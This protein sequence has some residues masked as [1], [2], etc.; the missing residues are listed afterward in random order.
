MES[1]WPPHR[2]VGSVQFAFQLCDVLDTEM[3]NGSGQS[4]VRAPVLEHFNEVSRRPG[5]TGRVDGDLVRRSLDRGRGIGESADSSA[6]GE[7]NKQTARR[8]GDY[9]EHRL[10]LIAGGR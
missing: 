2:H 6:D 1:A 9:V 3:E 7:R 10:A 5:A 8:A 4:R